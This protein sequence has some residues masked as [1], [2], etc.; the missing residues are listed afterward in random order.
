VFDR[1]DVC[2][3]KNERKNGVGTILLAKS[4]GLTMLFQPH[5]PV[6]F[7]GC[8][9]LHVKSVK[10]T[11]FVSFGYSLDLFVILCVWYYGFFC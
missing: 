2:I 3:L 9:R 5:P 7:L 1:F 4:S 8:T 6:I 11:G 10:H